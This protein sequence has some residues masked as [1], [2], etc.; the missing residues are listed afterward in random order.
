MKPPDLYIRGTVCKWVA[1][2]FLGHDTRY[3]WD[4]SRGEMEW[5]LC[6][7][8]PWH[9]DDWNPF[10]VMNHKPEGLHTSLTIGAR[11]AS[12]ESQ[13]M[14]CPKTSWLWTL[15]RVQ[16]SNVWFHLWLMAV[17]DELVKY[18][19]K[20]PI[21]YRDRCGNAILPAFVAGP[22]QPHAFAGGRGGR[23][24]CKRWPL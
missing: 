8:I 14:N 19:G 9:Q 18:F 16:V 21:M 1:R 17:W 11:R 15:C 7:L 2:T 4:S 3:F 12:H 22:L 24:T 23:P 6:E 13:A 20:K 10:F 5:V